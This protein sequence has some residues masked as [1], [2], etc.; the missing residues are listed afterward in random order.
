MTNREFIVVTTTHD[1]EDKARALAAAVVRER[2]AACA[3]VYPINSVYWWD[4]D[5]QTEAEWRIDFKTRADLATRLG[6][7]ITEQHSYDTPEVVVVP[8]KDGSAGY[9][10]WLAAETID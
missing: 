6:V 4:G 5:V 8:I 9:L 2:L 10:D 7:F 1:S 3:Q